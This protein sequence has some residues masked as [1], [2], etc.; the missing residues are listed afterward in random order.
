MCEQKEYYCPNPDCNNM[1]FEPGLCS[2]CG[3]ELEEAEMVGTED[4]I[5][6]LTSLAG[7]GQPAKTPHS[8]RITE[9]LAAVP[10]AH[11]CPKC[12]AAM[13]HYRLWG[14]RCACGGPG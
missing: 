14:Y 5:E 8:D 3:A 10:P 12:G 1:A 6:G 2:A 13:A 4:T 11:V 7:V 9:L